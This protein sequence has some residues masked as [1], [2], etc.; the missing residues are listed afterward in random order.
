MDSMN[1]IPCRNTFTDT[2]LELGLADRDILA[3]TSDARGSVT[4]SAFAEQLPGQFVEVGIAEQNAIGIAAGLASCGKKVF[5]CGPA[6]FYTSRS[7]EQIKVDVDYSDFP[8]KI[9]GVSGGV[10]YGALGSTHHSLH[11]IAVLRCFPNMH[12]LLPCDRAQT[13]AMT[14]ALAGLKAPAYMRMGRGPVPDV[15]VWDDCPFEIGK[16]NTL[17][18]GKDITLIGCGETVWH[19]LEAA[20]K[21]RQSGI[22][23]RVLDLHT[24]KPLDTHALTKAIDETGH[25]VTVEEHSIYGGLGA[26]VAEF[27]AQYRPV[28]MRLIG[29]PDEYAEHGSSAEIFRHYGIT[30]DNIAKVATNLLMQKPAL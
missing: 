11:D 8:V 30:G 21:L 19:C 6:C 24:L 2:L 29:I 14:N 1:S 15:Y 18:S 20:Q 4:L 23:A 25:I 26:I 17:M 5:V 16:A 13:R 3:V 7:L 28:P 22:E 9:I 10:S 12:I 27:A